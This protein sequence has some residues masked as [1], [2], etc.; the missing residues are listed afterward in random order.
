MA[1]LRLVIRNIKRRGWYFRL[2]ATILSVA[3]LC[4]LVSLG[5]LRGVTDRVRFAEDAELF[6]VGFVYKPGGSGPTYTDYSSNLVDLLSKEKGVTSIAVVSQSRTTLVPGSDLLKL[7][8]VNLEAATLLR[9]RGLEGAWLSEIDW[10]GTE[11]TPMPIVVSKR[12]G[13]IGQV[14][15]LDNVDSMRLAKVVGT[16]DENAYYLKTGTDMLS[17]APD[18]FAPITERE[19]VRRVGDQIFNYSFYV[20]TDSP[21]TLQ[22][23]RD[24]WTKMLTHECNRLGI[25]GEIKIRTMDDWREDFYRSSHD[26][27]IL[28]LWLTGLVIVLTTFGY[29]SINAVSVWDRGMEI[30]IYFATGAT[31]RSVKLIFLLEMIIPLL[32]PAIVSLL[33]GLAGVTF[34]MVLIDWVVVLQTNAV[35]ILVGLITTLG[36]FITMQRIRP[37]MLIRGEY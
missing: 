18:I 11:E 16:F 25:A 8:Y 2:T 24:K 23:N 14:L 30:G 34:N 3:V 28:S 10:N 36:P 4:L 37:T 32:V 7:T 33:V 1:I 6:H 22:V 27:I 31:R 21:R 19:M 9:P 35:V 29:G 26:M 12:V 20:I 5:A 13:T 17:W 15:Q